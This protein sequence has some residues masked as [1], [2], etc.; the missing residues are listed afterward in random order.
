MSDHV[1]SLVTRNSRLKAIPRT[2]L[3]VLAAFARDDGSGAFPSVATIQERARCCRR[4]VQNALRIARE[5]D[6]LEIVYNFGPNGTNRYRVRIETFT[7]PLRN[8]KGEG[9]NSARGANSTHKGSVLSGKQYSSPSASEG[10]A[11][12]PSASTPIRQPAA[13]TRTDNAKAPD[14]AR[15]SAERSCY[16]I[17]GD[18][19]RYGGRCHCDDALQAGFDKAIGDTL[20]AG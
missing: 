16:R 13:S 1:L 20:D 7:G 12:N 8:E 4:S 11:C 9:A 19:G 18:C 6:E 17:C 5:A 3:M 10:L 2:V 15:A 14:D